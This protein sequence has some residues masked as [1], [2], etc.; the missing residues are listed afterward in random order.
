VIDTSF[1]PDGRVVAIMTKHAGAL[2][3]PA[4][5][6]LITRLH[7]SGDIF[8]RPQFSPDG[9]LLASRNANGTDVHVWDTNSGNVHQTGFG[10]GTGVL[11]GRT[12]VTTAF[13]ADNRQLLTVY[14]FGQLRIW[15]VTSGQLL[16]EPPA[17]I[18]KRMNT[19]LDA[20]FSGDRTR[21]TLLSDNAPLYTYECPLCASTPRLLEQADTRVSNSVKRNATNLSL[22]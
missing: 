16:I 4:T 18:F 5:G 10:P 20:V 7:G 11:A 17:Q 14:D 22:Q 15:D 6:E 3:D 1:S 12:V 8:R 9:S 21:V 2:Y 13:S 19:V